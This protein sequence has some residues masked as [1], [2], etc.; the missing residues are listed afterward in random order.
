M[1][2]LAL[3][4]TLCAKNIVAL[5]CALMA[6]RGKGGINANASPDS[7]KG[8]YERTNHQL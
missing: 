2:F 4:E 5:A 7:P 8:G 1:A 3:K 6:P